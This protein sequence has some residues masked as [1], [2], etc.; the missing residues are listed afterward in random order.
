MEIHEKAIGQMWPQLHRGLDIAQISNGQCSGRLS[1]L[2]LVAPRVM[3]SRGGRTTPP[4]AR[5]GTY[6]WLDPEPADGNLSRL[7][8]AK[9]PCCLAG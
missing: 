6:E 2:R 7:L 3:D 9:R 5:L 8:R 1:Q 4:G